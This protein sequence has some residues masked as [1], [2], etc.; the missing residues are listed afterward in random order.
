MKNLEEL[1]NEIARIKLSY[2]Q[3]A[4]VEDFIPGKE[5]TVAML[6]N[7]DD[8]RV[9]PIVEINLD[10]VPEG[11][12]KIYSYE[13]KWFFDTRENQLDIFKCPAEV[14]KSIYEHIE[15]VCK[16]TFR[17]LRISCLFRLFRH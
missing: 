3:P 6:G 1:N 9:L 4:L 11:F 10:S 7:G 17:V 15:R 12:N 2:R 8:L 13:V 14:E 5:F 16:D